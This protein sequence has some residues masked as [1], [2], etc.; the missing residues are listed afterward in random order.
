[1]MSR[2]PSSTLVAVVLVFAACRGASES[3]TQTN[4]SSTSAAPTAGIQGAWNI[5]DYKAG[6][7]TSVTNPAGLFIFATSQYSIMYSNQPTARPPFADAD[8]PTDSEKLRAF[9]TFIA[10][11]G[12]YELAGDTLTVHPAI[13]KHPNYMAGGEDRF[14]VRLA[15][16]T[17]FLTSIA[18]A[19]RWAGG[20]MSSD[21]TTAVD[22]FKLVRAR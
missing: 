15:G 7:G 5:A 17:L 1:M 2:S 18:G 10:N 11:S 21:T 12:N 20:K 6:N 22:N 9:D 4:D 8:S 13:S 3:S 19:F 16:D 14:I